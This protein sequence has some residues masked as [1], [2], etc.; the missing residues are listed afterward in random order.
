[1]LRLLFQSNL[2]FS[3]ILSVTLF[4][5]DIICRNGRCNNSVQQISITSFLRM[6]RFIRCQNPLKGF[7]F[8]YYSI[9]VMDEYWKL[10]RNFDTNN[11]AVI[12]NCMKTT[13]D[14]Y[15]FTYEVDLSEQR[16][17][18]DREMRVKHLVDVFYYCCK[19][20]THI[21]GLS[22][23]K[24]V[25]FIGNLLLK[26]LPKS[27]SGT[28]NY[29]L[30]KSLPYCLLENGALA[31]KL[32]GVNQCVLLLDSCSVNKIYVG[33]LSVSNFDHLSQSTQRINKSLADVVSMN[34]T[35]I[36]PKSECIYYLSPL[37][38]FFYCCCDTNFKLCAYT[39]DEKL[40]SYASKNAKIWANNP[41]IR[42]FREF[43]IH[44]QKNL[45]GNISGRPWIYR[46][47]IYS[48]PIVDM[49]TGNTIFSKNN[50]PLHLCAIGTYNVTIG[51][52]KNEDFKMKTGKR[53]LLA[54]PQKFCYYM[55][56]LQFKRT[57]RNP[58][59]T[60]EMRYG[61]DTEEI[62]KKDGCEIKAPICLQDLISTDHVIATFK[63]CCS[64]GDLCNHLGNQ[65]FNMTKQLISRRHVFPCISQSYS[66]L[67]IYFN[68]RFKDTYIKC[69]RFFMFDT[70]DEIMLI[71][72]YSFFAPENASLAELYKKRKTGK[73]YN[74]TVEHDCIRKIF[75]PFHDPFC[76]LFM[77]VLTNLIQCSCFQNLRL[78]E[79][80]LKPCDANFEKKVHEKGTKIAVPM[81]LNTSGNFESILD[82]NFGILGPAKYDKVKTRNYP[83]CY[84]M[85]EI[86][87][88]KHGVE[89]RS[90]PFD[91]FI[92]YL[93]NANVNVKR[94]RRR[95][96]F[97]LF[98]LD[99]NYTIT[100]YVFICFQRENYSP[101]N[102]PMNI[103]H[104]L[105]PDI[106]RE[107]SIKNS[108]KERSLCHVDGYSNRVNCKSRK[109]CFNF[110]TVH[111]T[112]L[113][114]CIDKIPKIVSME[115]KLR[116]LYACYNHDWITGKEGTRCSAVNENDSNSS[117]PLT[118]GIICCCRSTCS[119]SDINSYMEMQH[120]YFPFQI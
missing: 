84:D 2:I 25:N 41:E 54:E 20:C 109:G 70:F 93:H 100:R 115:P 96:I 58:P 28:Y 62:C 81:C 113:R 24:I 9:R 99:T 92:N 22:D 94:M 42:S 52:W 7:N 98:V 36:C 68:R 110:H 40:L 87:L 34:F 12:E 5:N 101:C 75:L 76:R 63:C 14:T 88:Y 45:L 108:L 50:I 4:T 116:L 23:D 26:N 11:R 57:D 55:A 95:M 49:Q 47:Y 3:Y 117:V 56:S 31:T 119:M 85:I 103:R 32:A 21:N 1:M 111:G 38:F 19:D 44:D 74:E 8:C 69:S 51:S 13:T 80:N 66:Y 30:G 104:Q 17:I 15:G 59:T 33:P 39:T 64:T 10:K 83:L 91:E 72:N 35:E 77:P 27:R 67:M 6:K 73:S 71:E 112:R 89:H 43:A 106:I 97:K 86:S 53:K 65:Y 48:R 37:E 16:Y 46:K 82:N 102:G 107:K 90:G 105:L 18:D 60:L 78:K 79:L 118:D 61:S 29:T 120:G 114:G